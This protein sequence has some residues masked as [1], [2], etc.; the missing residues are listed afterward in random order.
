MSRIG[1]CLHQPEF[2]TLSRMSTG[3]PHRGQ[4]VL[5]S[6]LFTMR[7]YGQVYVGGA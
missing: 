3:A 2:E 1:G 5:P 7:Q 6:S 4:V